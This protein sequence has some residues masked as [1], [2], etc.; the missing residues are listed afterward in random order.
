MKNFKEILENLYQEEIQLD[1]CPPENKFEFLGCA[2]FGFTTYDNSMA[3]EFAKSMI[4]VLGSIVDRKT[5]EYIET[6]YHNYLLMINMP[7][8][9]DKLEWGCSIRGA[10]LNDY[11]EYQISIYD[12]LKL[13]KKELTPFITQLIEWSES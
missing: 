4:S 7:F 1:N 10:W 8:L 13:E 11:K 5:F 2:I 12:E 6:N 3:A 9:T